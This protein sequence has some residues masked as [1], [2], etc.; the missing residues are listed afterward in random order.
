MKIKDGI[1]SFSDEVTS[2]VAGFNAKLLKEGRLAT[3]PEILYYHSY[4]SC[5]ISEDG[6]GN[7][8]ADSISR[9][10]VDGLKSIFPLIRIELGP[11][12]E[13]IVEGKV[14]PEYTAFFDKNTGHSDHIEYIK[15]I[16]LDIFK[17]Y[18]N[19]ETKIPR[20]KMYKWYFEPNIKDSSSKSNG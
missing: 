13:I 2:V 9:F 12:D 4:D 3:F 11:N 15:E 14:L 10:T 16:M 6:R 18:E 8:P 1:L 19:D 17:I 20:T 5:Y 7:T